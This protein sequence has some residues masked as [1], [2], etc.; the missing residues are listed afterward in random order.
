MFSD[1]ARS[2]AGIAGMLLGWRPGEFWRSTPEELAT[3]LEA[4][5]GK[6]DAESGSRADLDRL[7]R[8]FPDG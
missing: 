1:A 7:T 4:M 5:R 6:A 3:V 8:M 2:L